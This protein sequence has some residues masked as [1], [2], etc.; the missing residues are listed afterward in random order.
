MQLKVGDLLMVQAHKDVLQALR[1][2]RE[3]AILA[4]LNL[5]ALKRRKGIYVL[6]FF[7]AALVVG[8]LNLLPLSFCFLAAAI[9]VI[10]ARC[11]TMEQAY[12]LIDWRLLILIGGM[13]AFGTAIEQTGAAELLA[14]GIDTLL[15]PLGA[16]GVMAGYFVL[17]IL[18]TQPMS[19]A[20]AALVVLPVALRSAQDLGVNQ[21]TFA[22][23]IMLAA[24][25]SF[26]GPFEPSCILV[27]GPGKYRFI[28]FVKTGVLLTLILSLLVLTLIPVFW[29]LHPQRPLPVTHGVLNEPMSSRLGRAEPR[30]QPAITPG[31]A[32]PRSRD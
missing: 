8:G 24:S 25:I 28:D 13:T 5:P 19:N 27:Y 32:S 20:A 4:E 22:I 31:A 1:R 23:A 11:L 17:T 2:E 18:L 3:L 14:R 10:L 6:L 26:I 29:P 21:R 12:E 9:L 15:A 16:M 7:L 30:D